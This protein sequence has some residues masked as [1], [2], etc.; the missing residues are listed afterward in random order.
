MA[1]HAEATRVA[2]IDNPRLSKPERARAD[3]AY[4]RAVAGVEAIDTAGTG[5]TND[6]DCAVPSTR[7]GSPWRLFSSTRS[8]A[9]CLV[10]TSRT[11]WPSPSLRARGRPRYHPGRRPRLS[12]H[13][14]TLAGA[15]GPRSRHAQSSLVRALT[16]P[17]PSEAAFPYPASCCASPPLRSAV[18]PGA[19]SPRRAPGPRDPTGH[20]QGSGRDLDT[21]RP[22]PSLITPSTVE[23]PR[24]ARSTSSTFLSRPSTVRDDST[25]TSPISIASTVE[26]PTNSTWTSQDFDRRSAPRPTRCRRRRPFPA[27]GP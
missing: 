27:P 20:R 1:D 2:L 6:A 16:R 18:T 26:H 9:R 25:S 4:D 13:R 21:T 5:E 15:P 10:A 24:K 3:V 12:G 14:M 17:A 22:R 23:H 7:Q 19:L 11:C 8:L